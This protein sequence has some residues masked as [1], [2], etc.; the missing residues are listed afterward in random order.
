MA[1]SKSAL[2]KGNDGGM[3][4][5]ILTAIITIIKFRILQ[6]HFSTRKHSCKNIIILLSEFSIICTSADV[7]SIL[8]L[9]PVFNGVRFVC[10]N[11]IWFCVPWLLVI[12]FMSCGHRH[13]Q[14]SHW[15]HTLFVIS[16][17]TILPAQNHHTAGTWRVFH[18]IVVTDLLWSWF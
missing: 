12:C 15:R 2:C 3:I 17:V 14:Y 9:H 7:I 11:S 16:D 8:I 1:N 10:Q 13:L 4:R 5:E 18:S 6:N